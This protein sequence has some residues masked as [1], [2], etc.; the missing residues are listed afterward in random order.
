MSISSIAS[1]NA[2]YVPHGRMKLAQPATP[3]PAKALAATQALSKSALGLSARSS[4]VADKGASIP[5]LP[6]QDSTG[7]AQESAG[8]APFPEA[9]IQGGDPIF[10]D[11]TGDAKLDGDDVTALL[12]A[13]NTSVAAADLNADGN[14]DTADLGMLIIAIQDIVK[15]SKPDNTP[16]NGP[17]R[18]YH[19][20]SAM[21]IP[22]DRDR[23]T[24]SKSAAL[25]PGDPVSETDDSIG[26]DSPTSQPGVFGD[27]TGDGV[28]NGD[29]LAMLRQSFGTSETI[30]DLNGDGRVDTA[31]LGSMIGLLNKPEDA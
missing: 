13:F 11:I 28:V 10:G 5:T 12:K 25:D 27:L 16:G 2:V 7:P 22:S 21:D 6:A 31:D 17:N 14:V 18:D 24:E 23:F 3:L 15:N 9:V 19:P 8:G 30:G 20:L 1:R 29:D 26:I 4:A